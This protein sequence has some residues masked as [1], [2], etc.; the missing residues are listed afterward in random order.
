ML[1][2][3]AVLCRFSYPSLQAWTIKQ[4]SRIRVDVSSSNFPAYAAH[5]NFS[6]PWAEQ[7][8]VRIAQQTL[9]IGGEQ[10]Y[11]EFPEASASLHA[12]GIF[13]AEGS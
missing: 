9:Y 12:D 13:T 11:V 4:G 8:Q 6:G 5:S 1:Y 10:S 2:F 3:T 7:Q